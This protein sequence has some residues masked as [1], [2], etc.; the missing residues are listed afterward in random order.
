[1][2]EMG[3]GAPAWPDPP[4]KVAKEALP[5]DAPPAVK[6]DARA[7]QRIAGEAVAHVDGVLGVKAGMGDLLKGE[8]DKTAGVEVHVSDKGEADVQVRII[9][10][11]GR[12]IPEVADEV[13]GRIQGRLWSLAGVVTHRV[14]VE[15]A[16]TMTPAEYDK[17]YGMHAH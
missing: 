2:N 1:M 13:M 4:K 15:V 9:T 6:I 7:M 12:S 16:D 17:Q 3:R 11:F 5:Q 8:D 14:S 10:E